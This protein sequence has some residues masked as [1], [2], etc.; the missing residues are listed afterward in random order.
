MPNQISVNEISLAKTHLH[1]GAIDATSV[2]PASTPPEPN[3]SSHDAS[4]KID[5]PLSSSV[6]AHQQLLAA[7]E[8]QKT[9]KS[10]AAPTLNHDVQSCLR[11]LGEP[12]CLFG[13]GVSKII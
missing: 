12:I 6:L 3:E 9:A 2:L 10:I 8:L 11:E 13:E 7:F 1:Y 4:G 5:A